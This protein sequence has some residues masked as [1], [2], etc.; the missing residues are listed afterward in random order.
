MSQS[1]FPI[2]GMDAKIM[3]FTRINIEFLSINFKMR[4]FCFK[5]KFMT[6]FFVMVVVIGVIV[7]HFSSVRFL[8]NMIE[9]VI[10]VMKE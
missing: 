1:M 8:F 3:N 10:F 6:V 4:S 2:L 7:N 5:T 9:Y